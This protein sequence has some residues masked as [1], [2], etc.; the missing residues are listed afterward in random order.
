MPSVI[1]GASGFGIDTVAGSGRH[2]GTPATTVLRVT[3]LNASGTG[4]LAW[5]LSQTYPRT[6]IFDVSGTIDMNDASLQINDPYCTV[7]GQTAPSPGI[8]VYYATLLVR[9]GEVLIQHMRFRQSDANGPD[10]N[11]DCFGIAANSFTG[12]ISNVVFDHCSASWSSDELCSIFANAGTPISNCTL[13]YCLFG[14]PLRDSIHPSGLHNFGPLTNE[15]TNNI[16]YH[17]NIVSH[18]ASRYP[19]TETQNIEVI[20]N[21][22]Q[23]WLNYATYVLDPNSVAHIIGNYYIGGPDTVND[24]LRINSNVSSNSVYLSNNISPTNNG[25]E[26]AWNGVWDETNGAA[27]SNNLLFTASGITALSADNVKPHLIKQCGARPVDRDSVDDRIIGYVRNENGSYINS[28]SDVGGLP[29]LANNTRVLD[30]PADPDEVQSSG[31]TNLEEWLQGFA[32]QIEGKVMG[33][34]V[35]QGSRVGE[36]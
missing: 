26:D 15:N 31:Y 33:G 5:A 11:R 18:A 3:N 14:E 32:K 8:T 16:T 1:P 6:I 24:F 21:V 35:R 28:P 13:R 20:N 27:R 12:P 29:V 17:C 10:S 25:T 2:L 19:L 36:R 9:T 7:A 30:L 22:G 23:N 4:S 34:S